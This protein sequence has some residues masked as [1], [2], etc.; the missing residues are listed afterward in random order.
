MKSA[1]KAFP[2]YFSAIFCLVAAV[3]YLAGLFAPMERIWH[4]RAFVSRGE[5]LDT[6]DQ[7]LILI[8]VDDE[9]TQKYGFPLPRVVYAQALD[10]LREFGVKTV[11][12]DVLFFE[13]RDGDAELAA[14]TKRHGGVVHLFT[15]ESGE[16]GNGGKPVVSMA[17]PALAAAAQNL[18][19]PIINSHLES[20]G[21]IRTFAL[22]DASVEDP[23]RKGQPTASLATVSIASFLGKKVADL[24]AE[25]GGDNPA[26]HVLNYRR[27]IEWL[28]H[29]KDDES[30]LQLPRE[31]QLKS[32]AKVIGSAYRT[33]SLMD[34]LAG[35]LTAGQRKALKGSMSMI[36]STTTGYYDHYPTPFSRHAPGA[37]YHLNVMDNVLHGDY[38][39]AT[40]VLPI[41]LFVIL[42]AWLPLILTMV[43]P[44]VVTVAA[45]SAAALFAGVFAS[46]QMM[47]RGTMIYPVAPALTL[48]A[49]YLVITVHR[50]FTEGAEKQMIKAKF[51]QFVSPEIV[52]ELANDPEKAK[53]GAQKREMT[54]LFLDIAHFTTISEKMGP[55]ALMQF[56]NKYLSALSGVMLDRRGTIDKYIGD[57][58]MAFWNAPLEN[59]AHARDAVLSALECQKAITEL[60]K[61]LDPGL[62]ETPAI[63]IGINTGQMNVG[64]TGTERKL[65]YTV[66]G[67]EVNLAS[68][69]E[70]ANKFFGSDIM[71]SSA[72]YEGSKDA[73]EAR[74]LGRARVVGKATPVPVYEPLAK[75]GDLSAVWAKALPV[76]EKGVKAFYDK[77]YEESLA[78]FG[79]FSKLMPEDGPGELYLNLSRDYT[80]L[81][82]DDWD[83]V[84]NLT[85]K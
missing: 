61:N 82:P 21:H 15:A 1:K 6:G 65:A 76:W 69:L 37:E 48:I 64:F 8:A 59:S 12:F 2:K 63:R 5:K 23:V 14:A 67:D 38:L 62:P 68:R 49:S 55:E 41:L 70:G 17:I 42:A 30:W 84:F 18:G 3:A 7:R 33:I 72:T 20:D 71:I 73:I 53:L 83:Q 27:P 47:M 36:G 39:R 74:Y 45:A 60:N 19:S 16:G 52:E 32:S 44:N 56:L 34:I 25:F 22:F 54:V 43:L 9:T 10:K 81:P 29:E 78:A 58:I 31:L 85:A 66:I 80:A 28:R 11:V 75:K 79:D 50:V 24:N 4:D 77:K 40:T 13:K 57:C 26:L 46:S 51:G 35:R